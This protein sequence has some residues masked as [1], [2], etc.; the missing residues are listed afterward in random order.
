MVPKAREEEMNWKK[1]ICD[2][3]PNGKV[4][5]QRE[6]YRP[7]NDGTGERKRGKKVCACP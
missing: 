7:P 1:L 2:L 4:M 6:S 5:K 3:R